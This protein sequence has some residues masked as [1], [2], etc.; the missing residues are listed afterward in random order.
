[1]GVDN[2]VYYNQQQKKEAVVKSNLSNSPSEIGG[3]KKGENNPIIYNKQQTTPQVN[4]EGRSA[5]SLD[6][7]VPAQRNFS[8]PMSLSASNS[9]LRTVVGPPPGT[10][11]RNMQPDL[12]Y[13]N[14]APVTIT[15]SVTQNIV[16]GN[17][18]T[19][20]AGG[21]PDENSFFR[22]FD[23]AGDFGITDD[24]DVSSA[25]FAVEA[26]SGA[27]NLTINI[28]STTT[29][30]PGG[31]PG[32][33]TLQ[34]TANYVSN[35]ADAGTVV[36]V[37]ITATIPAG[38]IMIYELKINAGATASWFPGS[39]T[40]GQ[41]GVS[42][43]MS[44][45]CAISTPTDLTAIGFPNQHMV[46]NIVG[47]EAGGGGAFP[48]PYCGPLDFTS[49][50]EPITLV[51]VAGISNVTDAAVNGTPD[52]EDFTAI[53][54]D[55]EAGMSYPIALE[56]NTDGNFTNRFVVFIDWNQNGVLND[57]GEVYEITD[58]LINSTGVDGQQSNGTIDVPAGALAGTTRMRVKKQFGTTNYLDPCLATGF[59]QAED[60]SINVTTGGGGGG[61]CANAVIE[62]NQD[63]TDACMANISQG[64]LAQ[65]YMPLEAQ[66]AGAG[67]MFTATSTGLDVNLSL[68]DGLPNAGGTMLASGT[69]QTD[70]TVW[71]DVFWDP[72]VNVTVGNTYYIVIDGD[73]TLPCI[74]GA[75]NNP[76]AGGNVF[77]NNYTPFANFDYTFRTYSCDGGGG[78]GGP[79]DLTSASNAFENG[80]SFTKN[81]GRITAND[82][83]VADGE[84]M[85]LESITFNAFIGGVGSGVNADNV[86]VFIYED[87]GSGAPGTL[88]TSQTSL[89]PDSQVVVG[90]N[91]GFDAWSIELDIADVNLPGQVGAATTYWIGLSLEPTDG[92][93]TFW[94][95][96]TAAVIGFGL[97][98]DD[99]VAGFITE[100]TN[101]GV[102]TFAATCS[103][104]GG[105]GNPCDLTSASNAFENGKSFTKNLG[106]ITANDISV[107]DGEDMLLES[108]TF[109]AFI[110]GVGSGVNA[111]NV[112]V[113][114]YEDNGSGAPGTLVTSQ[115]SLV[116]DS[117]VV[118]GN[119]FGFDAW[120]IELDIADVN[121]PGQVGAATTYWI[122]LSLEPTD[123]SNTFWEFSTAAVIG[124][125][126]SYDDGVAGF[127]TEPTNEG[128]YTF[129]AT[130]SP[131]GGGGNYDDCS[132]AIALAC[133]DS[134]TGETLTATDSGGNPAPD[135]FYKFTGNGTSQ[136]VTISLC[137]GGTDYDSVLRV[138]DDCDLLNELAFNDDSCGLQSEVSFT[139]DGTS[140]YYIMVEGFGSNS[141]NFSLDV[142]CEDPLPNDDCSGAIAVSCGDSVTGSTVGA[143]VDSGAPACGPAITSP[144]VWYKL[145]DNSGLPGDI[146]LSLCNGTDFDSKI[147]VYSGTCAALVCIDGNDDACG[148]QSEITFA[149][150]GNTEYYILIH[151]FGGATGNFTMDVTCSPT[152]PPNDMIVNSIDVDEIGFPYT[153][154]SVAMPAATT[155]DG[156]PVN[157]DLTGANGVWYNFVPSG[158]GT[159]NAT[160]VT[161]GGAS[162]VT[163]YTA[164]NENAVE[165]DL[166]LVPQQTNQCAPGTSASIFT[167]GGQAYYVFVMNTG[168]VTDIV[169]D[170]T[171]IGISENTIAGFSYYPNPTNGILNLNSVE[172]IENVSMYNLLGQLVIES[173]VNA[174]TSQVDISG[175]STGTYLM[176]VTVN[177]ETGTYKVLKQ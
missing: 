60:Y 141:G 145:N 105:G 67:I 143:T 70:G 20:N 29:V 124:F 131:I 140:T 92:S 4:Y 103:P 18:V 155:E 15:H 138:F 90:N 24:F 175:L 64:G 119:N 94:E 56:G 111:D 148:L 100:P 171:N 136:L 73:P 113:F 34:G 122:G 41:T 117:Q 125:G 157:C 48:A 96:S 6:D 102:Y 14:R 134:V 121:L 1:M 37:P 62:V 91:F 129:A 72:V 158:D 51:E 93:N 52:H 58:L 44:A 112:D 42:W 164:P 151:S 32:S 115:T 66:S 168:A 161:P 79:C 176:K 16:A 97:S 11:S 47:E 165:T 153:D 152:P 147:S 65:S 46:M 40:G 106:R 57:A 118:V 69:S 13:N 7:V 101:E 177:G 110:G 78:T 172:N 74:A 31:Y 116:P 82:I 83:S 49:N 55:M 10:A 133:G 61:A 21:I 126:L 2:P 156:N 26:V 86:D 154:P 123:G 87:N 22:D 35:V 159:A 43:I 114:I 120:S 54:G 99:G 142:T 5:T 39:N 128:V 130:C 104:I 167:L 53:S 8:G 84:D 36:S 109:N 71:A 12:F 77:A 50:V 146:T 169:I 68:W 45:A 19:C 38:E 132:G 98:Y 108:I 162:S 163:F 150:D 81:L 28:Y 139:S 107:A 75:L 127:I 80:K 76:Y 9:S 33:A 137:G 149:S 59:G 25:E 30:F 63:F 89:V 174:T 170:G 23:L 144:G 166:T 88:V 3:M 85:L 27:T 95:F 160:I 173:R 135:V 17:S